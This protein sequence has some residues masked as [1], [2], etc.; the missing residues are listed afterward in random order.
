M[1]DL[2][3]TNFKDEIETGKTLVFFWATWCSS[4]KSQEM[5]LD[6][7]EEEQKDKIKFSKVNIS[8]NRFISDAQKVRNIPS[9]IFYNEGEEVK[10]FSE[11][12][13]K[14]IIHNSISEFIKTK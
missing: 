10:R 2:N 1:K 14:S 3:F 4:C 12:T 5:I 9:I 6:S 8:D 13:S 7:I 11:T